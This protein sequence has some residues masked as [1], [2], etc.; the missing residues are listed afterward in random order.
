MR[1]LFLL[2]VAGLAASLLT[3][4]GSAGAGT[5]TGATSS[6]TN[7][8]AAQA[9][10]GGRIAGVLTAQEVASTCQAHNTSDAA[11]GTPPLIWHGGPMMGTEATGPV[12]VTPIF[13]NPT[14]HPMD[15][16][17]KAI[18]T[19]YLFDVAVDSGQHTNV[20]STLNEYF[21]SNGN[22]QYRV[23][24]GI[25]VDDHQPL[26]ADGCTLDNASKTGIYAD[27]S[28]YDSCLD[29]DQVI[30]ET[31]RVV[32]LQHMPRDFAHIYIL[33][34]PKHVE[35][36]FYPGSTTVGG[37]NFC[38]INN[39]PTTTY[40]AYHSIS[41]QGMVYANLPYPIYDSASGFTCGSDAAFPTVQS[42]NHN[43]DADT[44]VSPTS[45]EIMESITDPDTET[46]W[47]DSNFYENGDECAYVYGGTRGA[48]GA[49]YNQTIFFHH[50]LTQEEFSNKDFAVTGKGCLPYE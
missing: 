41:P 24:L 26:P 40:C 43:L 27:G 47:Y 45:H 8:C 10:A 13:W 21:G 32:K 3:A 12:I 44:E 34:V 1:K 46:G 20:F 4:A 29:D 7:A 35:T 11:D 25:P 18:I 6:A 50:Y 39:L 36:C 38:T 16:R 31:N 15:S 49:L 5:S 28:G 30:A 37:Q 33:F 19:Q 17:Y 23:K 48:P 2:A 42:P 14:G 22:I 9:P